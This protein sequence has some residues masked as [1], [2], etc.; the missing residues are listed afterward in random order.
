MAS[1][2]ES[3]SGEERD[4]RARVSDIEGEIA[5]RCVIVPHGRRLRHR[6]GLKQSA[7]YDARQTVGCVVAV[8]ITPETR[9]TASPSTVHSEHSSTHLSAQFFD[10]SLCF[11]YV[12]LAGWLASIC[13]SLSL[14]RPMMPLRYLCRFVQCPLCLVMAQFAQASHRMFVC[15]HP[16]C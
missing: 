15:A 14:G 16:S 9:S 8:S 4:W 1:G 7:V 13:A 3:R 12:C 5:K 2:S 6:V 10:L 11:V